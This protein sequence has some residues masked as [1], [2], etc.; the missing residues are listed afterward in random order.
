MYWVGQEFCSGFS[1][2][3][4][5]KTQT[6]FFA[7]PVCYICISIQLRTTAICC[8]L[9]SQ[10]SFYS[11][12]FVHFYNLD[13]FHPLPHLPIC[14][15]YLWILFFSDL[16]LSIIRSIYFICPQSCPAYSSMH[17]RQIQLYTTLK[18][19]FILSISPVTMERTWNSALT[20]QGS[21]LPATSY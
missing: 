4:Y 12:K 19:S 5:G 16:S 3:P 9:Y 6:N 11:R 21:S 10:G 18:V 13:P 15:L 17:T 7:N 20:G 8:T 1:L 14:F 2:T